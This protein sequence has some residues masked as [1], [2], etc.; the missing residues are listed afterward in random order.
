MKKHTVLFMDDREISTVRFAP[1]AWRSLLEW[2][3]QL[4][5]INYEANWFSDSPWPE[6]PYKLKL[7]CPSLLLPGLCLLDVFKTVLGHHRHVK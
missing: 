4:Q 6:S 5:K 7:C 1:S 2:K 3:L